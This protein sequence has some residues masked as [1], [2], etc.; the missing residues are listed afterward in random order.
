MG[1]QCI[2]VGDTVP[3]RRNDRHT[4]IENRWTTDLLERYLLK[5]VATPR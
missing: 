3:T 2:L 5:G 4:G 1:E